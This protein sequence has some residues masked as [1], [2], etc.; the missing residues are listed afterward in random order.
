GPV[1][2]GKEDDVAW[3]KVGAGHVRSTLV[4]TPD[5]TRNRVAGLAIDVPDKSGA[6][7]GRWPDSTPGIGR[8]EVLGRHRDDVPS[9]CTRRR[10]GRRRWLGHRRHD[11][12]GRLRCRHDDRGWP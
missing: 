8:S 6:V 7:K 11:D 12:R 3:L 2:T 9:I 4:L 5:V 10:S 1:G